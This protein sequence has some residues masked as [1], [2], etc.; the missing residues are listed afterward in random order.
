MLK[1]VYW[2]ISFLIITSVW[3]YA[4]GD[5]RY[6]SFSSNRTGNADIYT[7]DANGKNLRNITDRRTN[8]A[9]ATWSPDGRFLTYSSDQNGNFDIYVMD[10]ETRKNRRLIQDPGIDACA[11]W[12]PD[13]QWIAFCS[14]RS[15]AFEIYRINASGKNLQRLTR[16]PGNNTTPGWS[17][18]SQQIIFTS[19]Q[20]NEKGHRESFV[21][22]MR[23][24]GRNLRKFIKVA[25]GG[26]SWSPDGNQILFS[27]TRDNEDGEDTF[28]L[29]VINLNNQ[30]VRQLT[31]GPKWELAPQWSSD[32]QWITF[33][34]RE[35]RQN[36]TSAIYVM[37]AAGG[38]LRQL[39]DELSM[40][41]S[42]AWV[43]VRSALSVQ[44]NA[45]M[46]T[47]LWGEIKQE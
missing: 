33:E 16:L 19:S 5:V 44:S 18:D 9:D 37:N 28:D 29:F 34:A 47:T 6:I 27:T 17:P 4:A 32:G 13:G 3:T 42:P 23:A 15:G 22:V 14:N 31:Q 8:E 38:E 12:S 21:Y 11:A 24:D 46:L 43:P 7:I 36:K 39:T 2:A 20:R 40:N 25:A 1:T 10:I 41:W 26:P 35:P 45:S 30:G